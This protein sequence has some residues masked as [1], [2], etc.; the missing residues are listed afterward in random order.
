MSSFPY[1]RGRGR[2][3]KS[4]LLCLE[5]RF[6]MMGRPL[7]VGLWRDFTQSIKRG[8]RFCNRIF[9]YH[10]F[11][12]KKGLSRSISFALDKDKERGRTRGQGQ[13]DASI[14]EDTLQRSGSSAVSVRRDKRQTSLSP[15]RIQRSVSARKAGV[16]SNNRLPIQHTLRSESWRFI[17][18]GLYQNPMTWSLFFIKTF[19]IKV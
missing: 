16:I 18:Y 2:S 1:R 10:I 12:N 11:S 5:G 15:G 17:L 8:L 9:L 4:R 6:G 7:M 3:P 14:Y 19:K 13:V